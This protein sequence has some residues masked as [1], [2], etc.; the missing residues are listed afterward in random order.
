MTIGQIVSVKLSQTQTGKRIARLVV[1]ELSLN[2]ALD[3][4]VWLN[5]AQWTFNVGD[6]VEMDMKKGK[7]FQGKDQYS[8]SIE[9]IKL[10]AP[11]TITPK[12]D[13]KQD[14]PQDVWDKKDRRMCRMNALTHATE[15]IKLYLSQNPQPTPLSASDITGL[16]QV[17]AETFENWI[18]RDGLSA[19]D[20]GFPK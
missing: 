4:T 18:Y 12:N 17:E 1:K 2:Q 8:A 9:G 7:P 16:I 5:E 15:V 3:V 19:K 14:V 13:V 11:T 20:V 10:V 6:T